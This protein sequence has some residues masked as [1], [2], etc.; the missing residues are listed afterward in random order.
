MLAPS[1][2][3]SELTDK[4]RGQILQISTARLGP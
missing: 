1:F 2:A 3:G 4:K